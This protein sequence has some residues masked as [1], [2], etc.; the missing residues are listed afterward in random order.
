MVAQDIPKVDVIRRRTSWAPEEFYP[1]E[2][3][4]LESVGLTFAMEDIY[5]TINFGPTHSFGNAP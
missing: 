4:T 3:L 2:R 1:S 5:R